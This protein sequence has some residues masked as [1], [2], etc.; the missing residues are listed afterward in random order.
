MPVVY[1]SL[2]RCPRGPKVL[3]AVTGKVANMAPQ[4]AMK[5]G[6]RGPRVSNLSVPLFSE[7]L[8]GQKRVLVD[9]CAKGYL[10][11]HHSVFRRCYQMGA[12]RDMWLA[13][14][15]MLGCISSRFQLQVF[16]F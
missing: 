5:A 14:C 16:F 7:N 15:L 6:L 11:Q 12:A 8:R 9:F 2:E 4:Y 10:T 3:I 13:D 1:N